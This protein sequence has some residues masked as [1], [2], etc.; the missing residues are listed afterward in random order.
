[1]QL[2]CTKGRRKRIKNKDIKKWGE[3]CIK[4]MLKSGTYSTY[5]VQLY[6]L[7][8]LESVFRIFSSEIPNA[9]VDADVETALIKFVRLQR[10][11]RV[12][13]WSRLQSGNTVIR[14]L[15]KY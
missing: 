7:D 14:E 3:W 13:M 11:R 4:P 8:P 1:M 10:K 9:V 6:G 2:A 5:L 12:F 15:P